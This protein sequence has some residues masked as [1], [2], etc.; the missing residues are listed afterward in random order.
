MKDLHFVEVKFSLPLQCLL[1]LSNHRNKSE[2]KQKK[3][4]QLSCFAIYENDFIKF[5]A[6]NLVRNEF[7]FEKSV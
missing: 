3:R 7:S 4:S 1:K 5:Q 6:L 2:T